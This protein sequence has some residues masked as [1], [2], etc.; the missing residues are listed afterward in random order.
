MNEEK[1]YHGPNAADYLSA[2]AGAVTPVMFGR[3]AEATAAAA[4]DGDPNAR[5]WIAHIIFESPLPMYHGSP[6]SADTVLALMEYLG[7]SELNRFVR[8]IEAARQ[9]RGRHNQTAMN[10]SEVRTDEVRTEV[11]RCRSKGQVR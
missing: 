7:P 9:E 11:G 5:D 10:T 6:A 4:I 3:I 8:M 2:F 1:T